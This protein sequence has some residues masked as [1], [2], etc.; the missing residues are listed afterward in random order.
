M[1]PIDIYN[2]QEPFLRTLTRNSETKRVRLIKHGEQ[3][4]SLWDEVQDPSN[5]FILIDAT[6]KTVKTVQSD[7]VMNA[8]PHTFYNEADAAEDAVLFPDELLSLNRNV[9]FKEVSNAITRL[10][11]GSGT[12]SRYVAKLA[13]ESSQRSQKPPPLLDEYSDTDE[14]WKTG[15]SVYDLDDALSGEELEKGLKDEGS[16]VTKHWRLPQLWEDQ[17][18]RINEGH[19]DTTKKKTLSN[20]GLLEPLVGKIKKTPSDTEFAKNLK[21]MDRMMLLEKDRGDGISLYPII[22]SYASKLT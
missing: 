8:S 21:N 22:Y 15:D 3:V 19:I 11:D 12:M 16:D 7:D 17:I 13:L 10:E 1:K 18:T 5:T 14:S 6:N 4:K 9:P 20:T 2:H